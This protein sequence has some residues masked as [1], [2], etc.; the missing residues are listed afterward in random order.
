MSAYELRIS[1]WSSDVCS[2]DLQ[3]GV[4]TLARTP[5]CHGNTLVSADG[6]AVGGGQ[7]RLHRSSGDIGVH[8]DAEY[9]LTFARLALHIGCGLHVCTLT[10]RMFAIILN[11]KIDAAIF[12]QRRQYR[13]TKAVATAASRSFFAVQRDL[14][15]AEAHAPS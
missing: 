15:D 10:Q 3:Y 11:L 12:A 6:K 7:D 8:A 13:R 4:P 5:Y 2:S 9:F 14:A 1:D